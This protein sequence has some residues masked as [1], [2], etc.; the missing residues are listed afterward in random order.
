MAELSTL[1]RPYAK[2]VFELARE[3]GDLA[4]WS[5]TLSALSSALTHED[6]AGLIGHPALTRTQLGEALVEALGSADVQTKNLVRLLGDNGRLKLIPAI[7]AEY[8]QLRATAENRVDVR[9]TTATDADEAQKAALAEAVAKRLA[10]EVNVSWD[11][12]ASLVAGAVIRAGD[13]VIDGS[14]AG[15]LDRLRQAVAG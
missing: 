10:R 1:A 9:I 8:E 13:L 14:V 2:A 4:G 15:D 6:V 7:A 11:V 12:D 3:S 5:D